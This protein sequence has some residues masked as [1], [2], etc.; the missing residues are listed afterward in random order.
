M[1]ASHEGY[2][3]MELVSHWA[4]KYHMLFGLGEVTGRE[5]VQN[6]ELCEQGL[7]TDLKITELVQI[8]D[9]Q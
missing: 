1:L 9:L 2:C 5:G 3:S 4:I 6:T 7:A 8:K